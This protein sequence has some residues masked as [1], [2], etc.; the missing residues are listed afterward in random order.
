[1]TSNFVHV[2]VQMYHFDVYVSF[3]QTDKQLRKSLKEKSDLEKDDID[4][5]L[6]PE[7]N[8]FSAA[9]C[10]TNRKKQTCVIR[11]KQEASPSQIMA[12]LSHEI[13]HA[14][15]FILHSSG[16]KLTDDSEEAFAYLI[17]FITLNTL[18][19]V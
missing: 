1:M 6:D 11:I 19:D 17:G 15:V 7:N 3:H 4:Y 2:P 8:E 13:F 9:L 5:I 14:A 10:F 18:K 16:L 12:H